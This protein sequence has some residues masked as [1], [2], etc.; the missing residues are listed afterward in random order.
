MVFLMRILVLGLVTAF[1]LPVQAVSTATSSFYLDWN[2]A[3]FG[4]NAVAHGW[5]TVISSDGAK[6]SGASDN[7][8]LLP[9]EDIIDFTVT[10]SGATGGNGTFGL[11]D[12]D[13]FMWT[14]KASTEWPL[15]LNSEVVGQATL[16]G[17]WGSDRSNDAETGDFNLFANLIENPLAPTAAG[18]AFVIAAEG[19]LGDELALTSFRPVPIPPAFWFFGAA[20]LGLGRIGLKRCS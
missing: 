9:G 20:L 4:N 6:F 10:V 8:W 16:G 3:I 7:A 5:M 13:F 15:D 14:A 2:G 17:P 18:R 11:A 12:F 19:G 1:S